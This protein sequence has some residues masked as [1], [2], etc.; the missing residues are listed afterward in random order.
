MDL[1][2]NLMNWIFLAVLQVMFLA[3]LCHFVLFGV[4]PDRPPTSV[5]VMIICALFSTH[6]ALLEAHGHWLGSAIMRD[7][8]LRKRT[9]KR[10]K[11]S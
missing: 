5:G 9:P 1:G 4:E 7:V 11:S 3:A 8:Q 2:D 6:D 10:R